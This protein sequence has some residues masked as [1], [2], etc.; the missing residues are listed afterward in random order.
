MLAESVLFGTAEALGEQAAQIERKHNL[1]NYEISSSLK[2]QNELLT[3]NDVLELLTY[4]RIRNSRN[5]PV[6]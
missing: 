3:C 1:I 5:V 4:I 6:L 2:A